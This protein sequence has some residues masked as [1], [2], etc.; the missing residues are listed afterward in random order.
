MHKALLCLA[1]FVGIAPAVATAAPRFLAP[2]AHGSPQASGTSQ[3]SSAPSER[4]TEYKLPPELYQKAHNR[5]RIGFLTRI[6]AFLYGLAVLWFVLRSGLSA[7]YRDWAERG[8]PWRIGQALLFTAAFTLTIALL[9]LPIG[10]FREHMLKLYAISVQPWPSWFADRGKEQGLIMVVGGLLVWILFAFL[11]KSPRRWWLYFS[12]VAVAF[13]LFAVYISP[14]VI[15]PLFDTYEPLAGKAP[16]LVPELQ[17]ITRRAGLDVPPERMFWMKAS[18]KTVA[19]NA[20]V[21]G[22]GSSKRIVI[23]DTTL[24]QETSDEVLTDFGHEMGHYVLGHIWKGL[25]FTAPLVL[26]LL[27][28]TYRSIGP[29]LGRYGGVWKVRGVDDWAA[30]PALLLVLAVFGFAGQ[31]V[32]NTFSR[33]QEH[34]AD[35]YSME[36]ARGVVADPG[37]AAA[38]SFQIYGERVLDDPDP[39]PLNVFLF[40]THPTTGERVRF[41][42]TYDPWAHREG[43]QY[44]K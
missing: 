21:N 39:N 31:A 15:D 34:Q 28:A 2:A 4:I 24:A 41:F 25:L 11:R 13:L 19:T 44:V 12:A 1:L 32:A 17:K 10:L 16:Q 14:Y 33:H 35:V 23:W 26:V 8:S 43:P 20:S 29:L 7:R 5:G 30:L 27:Y 38:H 42:A 22:F 36:V 37:Q 40:F 6:V 18:D 3:I 9:Q